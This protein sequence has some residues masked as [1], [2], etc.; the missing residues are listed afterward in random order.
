MSVLRTD[1]GSGEIEQLAEQ[2]AP[3]RWPRVLAVLLIGTV[4]AAALAWA[5]GQIEW[6]RIEPISDSCKS[7]FASVIWRGKQRQLWPN[8]GTDDA[9]AG[10]TLYIPSSLKEKRTGE[11]P[12]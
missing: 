10:R 8:E 1:R 3:A 11:T 9:G 4:L 5:I 7:R 2:A 6:E 12:P